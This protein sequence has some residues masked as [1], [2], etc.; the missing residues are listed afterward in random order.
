MAELRDSTT[1][2]NATRCK[3]TANAEQHAFLPD[4]T[5]KAFKFHCYPSVLSCFHHRFQNTPIIYVSLF[6]LPSFI[7]SNRQQ[8]VMVQP[9]VSS[10]V[11]YIH[12]WLIALS[13]FRMSSSRTCSRYVCVMRYRRREIWSFLH[14]GQ[15]SWSGCTITLRCVSKEESLCVSRAWTWT[16]L[17]LNFHSRKRTRDLTLSDDAFYFLQLLPFFMDWTLWG[18]NHLHWFALL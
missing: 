6:W 13:R 7:M 3:G 14:R 8:R 1:W 12:L 5:F 15:K 10:D 2:L 17:V 16:H 18:T 9:I 4:R 11:K